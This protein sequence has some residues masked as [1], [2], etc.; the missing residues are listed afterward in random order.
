MHPP[1][2]QNTLT[3]ASISNN[4]IIK[5]IWEKIKLLTQSVLGKI[6]LGN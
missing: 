5:C 2:I 6:R 4:D 3:N 1:F